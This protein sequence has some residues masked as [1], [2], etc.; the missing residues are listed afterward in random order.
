MHPAVKSGPALKI[1]AK[2]PCFL[3]VRGDDPD[4]LSAA[5]RSDAEALVFDLAGVPSE[6]RGTVRRAVLAAL[7]EARNGGRRRLLAVRVGG[8]RDPLSEGDLDVVV[9]GGPDAVLLAACEGA[10]DLQRL[11][12]R[13]SV[14]EALHDLADGSTAIVASIDTPAGLLL[15]PELSRAAGRLAALTWSAEALAVH[16]GIPANDPGD[17]PHPLQLARSLVVF[18]ASS[19]GVAALD[20]AAPPGTAP[21]PLRRLAE[22][23]RRDGFAGMLAAGPDQ[24]T[25]LQEAFGTP[26]LSR[27]HPPGGA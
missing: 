20:T 4:A 5:L 13:L 11:S 12:A 14:R 8:I 9:T 7:R 22:S 19:S 27:R 23:A 10:A 17:W 15:L 2:T 1:D 6:R 26:P 25:V 21:E 16:L 24:F 18:A 3:L